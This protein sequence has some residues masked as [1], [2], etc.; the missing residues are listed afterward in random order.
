MLTNPL[1]IDA[2]TSIFLFSF[3]KRLVKI[4]LEETG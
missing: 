2:K 3:K 1:C 4:Y